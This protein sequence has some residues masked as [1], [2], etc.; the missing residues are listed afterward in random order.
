M[1]LVKL[2]VGRAKELNHNES[3]G[4]RAYCRSLVTPPVDSGALRYDTVTGKTDCNTKIHVV[5][6]N[7]RAYPE[8]LVRYYKGPRD[9]ERTK[10]ETYEDAISGSDTTATNTST[11]DAADVELGVPLISAEQPVMWMW[12][13]DNG[14]WVRYNEGA[15]SEIEDAFQR[16]PHAQ[17]RIEILPWTYEINLRENTQ[18]N[19]DHP[20]NRT[21][22]ICRIEG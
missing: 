16:D 22:N 12:E 10:F 6:D 13:A 18:T 19:L 17:I 3:E 21:R 7:G 9:P 11:V 20:N 4:M 1:F 8:Y 14:D 15:E 5:Y 2:L